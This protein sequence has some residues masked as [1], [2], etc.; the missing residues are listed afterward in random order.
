[1]DVLSNHQ[2]NKQHNTRNSHGKSF[3]NNRDEMVAN[4]IIDLYF[5]VKKRLKQFK[6]GQLDLSRDSYNDENS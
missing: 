6:K 2:T 5:N 1:M 4:A 3:S